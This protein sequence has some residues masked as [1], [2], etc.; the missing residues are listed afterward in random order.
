MCLAC[1]P[2]KDLPLTSNVLLFQSRYDRIRAGTKFTQ[3]RPSNIPV[4]AGAEY[5]KIQQPGNFAAVYDNP[6]ASPTTRDA[7]LIDFN[8]NSP[9]YQTVQEGRDPTYDNPKDL[10][11][12]I[13]SSPYDNPKDLM[14]KHDYQQPFNNGR[15]TFE[16]IDFTLHN[17]SAGLREGGII[18]III[19]ISL[20]NVGFSSS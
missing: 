12:Q 11:A 2:I 18:I 7:M 15:W 5:D 14:K 1:Q 17:W 20:I 10:L 6:M 9:E 13:K 3:K 4:V 8:D 19:I 16:L